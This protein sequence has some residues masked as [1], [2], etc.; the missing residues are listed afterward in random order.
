MRNCCVLCFTEKWL[1]PMSLDMMLQPEGLSTRQCQKKEKY[2]I[3]DELFVVLGCCKV[4]SH[5]SPH[6]L[7]LPVKCQQFLLLTEFSDVILTAIYIPPQAD[8]KLALEELCCS[9]NRHK[10]SYPITFPIIAEVF[11]LKYLSNYHQ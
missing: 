10:T 5:A 7:K 9:I 3:H 6:D 1:T 8:I 11:N 4:L 2:P